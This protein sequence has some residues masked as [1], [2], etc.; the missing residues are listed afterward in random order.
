MG[1]QGDKIPGDL[2]GVPTPL[3]RKTTVNYYGVVD[4]HDI[5]IRRVVK[6]VE[7]TS[8][9]DYFNLSDKIAFIGQQ[10]RAGLLTNFP[11]VIADRQISLRTYRRCCIGSQLVDWIIQECNLVHSRQQGVGMWQ[12][13]LEEGVLKHVCNE[14]NFED[15]NLFYRFREDDC[16]SEQG[17]PGASVPLADSVLLQECFTTLAKMGPD[18]LMRLMLRKPPKERTAED[19]DYIYEELL[20]IKAL[21]HLSNSVKREL[22]SCIQFESQE[23]SGTVL[24]K[25]GDEGKSWYIILKGSVNVTI[26]GKGVVGQLHEGDDFGKLALV[27]DA[28]RA[29]SIILRDERCHFLRVDKEDFNR[30]L[31]DVEAKTE[32]LKENGKDV[33]VLEKLSRSDGSQS[34]KYT[35]MAGTP[36]KM[37]E[38]ILDSCVDCRDDDEHDYFMED[39]FMTFNVFMTVD[40]LCT[41]LMSYYNETVK[42]DDRYHGEEGGFDLKATEQK[43]IRVVRTVLRWVELIPQKMGEESELMPLIGKL[44]SALHSDGMLSLLAQFERG[45]ENSD[46]LLLH[47]NTSRKKEGP[48]SMLWIEHSPHLA[49]MSSSSRQRISRPTIDDSE[50][51]KSLKR[52][53]LCPNTDVKFKVYYPDRSYCTLKLGLGSSVSE[54][55]KE[56]SEKLAVNPE[57]CVIFEMK[58][59]GEKVIFK[60]S[61]TCI[62]TTISHNGRLF[63]A[64]KGGIEKLKPLQEQ[65]GPNSSSFNDLEIMSSREIALQ[66]TLYDFELFN[67]VFESEFV[68][69]VFKKHHFPGKIVGNLDCFLARFNEVQ[70]WVISEI[71]LTPLLSKRVHLLR[72]F[73]KIAQHCRDFQ[74][75]M[76]FFGIIMGLSN[77]AISRL[78]QTWEKLPSKFKKLF[79]EFETLLDPTRNHRTYRLAVSKQESPFIPFMPLL[80]KDMTFIFEGNKTIIDGLINFEKMHMIANT[81]RYIRC[82]RKEN[83][84]GDNLPLVKNRADIRH[85]VRNLHVIDNQRTLSQL[86]HRL[87]KRPE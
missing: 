10:I 84:V 39:F 49:R 76:A 11:G 14:Y 53:P 48:S 60:E 29:A 51:S 78:S 65:E 22:A 8:S 20:H 81:I 1:V 69:S 36:E 46:N 19:L 32:R 68:F 23:G 6:C 71:C 57:D 52:E 26:F 12:V 7:R 72:K 63:A 42:T 27:N 56:A 4:F 2:A 41:L 3:L 50:E 59:T 9:I 66:M 40:R 24:I 75:M 73:I 70:H 37:V 18:A 45:L 83:F 77:I 25:Q 28:P 67:C 61:D 55:A 33:L 86:S 58:S 30:I 13:L 21:S 31:R 44:R 34:N 35:I 15:K 79:K 87:E 54:I 43:K 62:I 5:E 38:Y 16:G 64:P 80:M 17:P 74:N 85:Y 82:A 47:K